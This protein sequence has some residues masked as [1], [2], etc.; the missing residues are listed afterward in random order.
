MVIT[1][2]RMNAWQK[3][4]TMKLQILVVEAPNTFPHTHVQF[5]EDLIHLLLF[6]ENQQAIWEMKMLEYIKK[7]CLAS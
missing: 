5:H 3:R 4:A 1:F 7:V 6:H 2:K